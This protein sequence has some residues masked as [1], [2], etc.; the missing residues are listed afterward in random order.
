MESVV[1]RG[2]QSEVLLRGRKKACVP[3]WKEGEKQFG[4]LLEAM[5][6]ETAFLC[7]HILEAESMEFSEE[8]RIPFLINVGE[9]KVVDLWI[10]PLKLEERARW[11]SWTKAMRYFLI[12]FKHI[13]T[14]FA[15]N[16][17]HL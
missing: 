9:S 2:A 16:D 14:L 8:F 11:G 12:D 17:K 5:L 10:D 15:I 3:Q 6:A 7:E 1:L 13:A 4:E